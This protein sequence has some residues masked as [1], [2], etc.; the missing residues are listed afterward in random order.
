[1]PE[2]RAVRYTNGMRDLG[3][4][5]A[6]GGNRS[7]Y[8][9]AL[10]TAWGERLWQRV[11]AV[12]CV[13]AG[14]AM[15]V[16]LLSGRAQAARVYWDGLRRGITKNLDFSRLLRGQPVAPHAPIYRST[17]VHALGSGGLQQLQSTPFPIWISCAVPPRGLPIGV[18]TWLGLSA[19]AIEKRIDPTL[20]HP[21]VGKRLGFREFVFDARACVSADEVAD[22]VLASS[23]TPPFTP[24]GRFRGMNLLDGG[25]V[26]N[27]PASIVERHS[28]VRQ[29]LVLLTRPYPP[30]VTGV[31]GRRLYIEPSGPVP[32][33]RWDYREVAAVDATL[34]LGRC[35]ATAY[36]AQLEAWLQPSAAE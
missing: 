26:D 31:H 10:L 23:S 25:I 11:A 5:L 22:L 33:E 27:V 19:Y 4:T 24:V 21:E 28:E 12:S 8:Q 30:G 18:A 13:S 2:R 3:L 20:L 29:N 36:A 16:L 34:E 9:Q 32:I 17:I 1:L 6:G 15:A 14:A 7:F 35:D